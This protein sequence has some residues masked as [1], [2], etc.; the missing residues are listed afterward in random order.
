VTTTGTTT[1]ASTSGPPTFWR[2]PTWIGCDGRGPT[3][4]TRSSEPASARRVGP[5]S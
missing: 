2:P 3:S 1:W 4:P 5:R